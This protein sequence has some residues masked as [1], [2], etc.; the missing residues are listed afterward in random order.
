[1][2]EQEPLRFGVLL[3][4]D[5]HPGQT[6]HDVLTRAV[7]VAQH[8]E[9]LALDDVWVTEHH[10]LD[11]AVNPAP[12][13][14]AAFLLG[15]TRTIRVGTA[16]TVL[17]LHPPVHVAEQTALLDHLSAGRFVLGV[18]RGVPGAE[19]E[20]LGADPAAWRAGLAEPLDRLL[21]ALAGEVPTAPGRTG[22]CLRPSPSVR[23]RP[24]P[25]VYVAAGS[26]ASIEMAARRGLPLMLFFDK[27]AEA[28]AEMVDWYDR[29]A[30]TAG[31]QEPGPGHAFAVFTQV[32][33]SEERTRSLMRDRARFILS[34]NNQPGRTT[35]STATAPPPVTAGN[36]SALADRLLAT[37]PV[38][39]VDLCVE[40]LAHHI[41]AS[42]C[43]RVM[44]QV[45]AARGTDD[46]LRNLER[47]AREVFPAVR[48]RV[49]A[50]RAGADV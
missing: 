8:A 22:P 2:R 45:E 27:S 3:T 46:A 30:R 13:A 40:R 16:V 19:Y 25:P 33:E 38:G 48:E 32:T 26:P 49:G 12:L 37:Q 10:F 47:L 17:P 6:D 35:G 23:T 44:C 36:V 42:G 1:M 11:S 5:R 20:A 41:R 34:L 29:T 43:T 15:R 18:G 21:A 28:K 24:R 31:R 9:C 50:A 39:S 7:E 14:L 4:T